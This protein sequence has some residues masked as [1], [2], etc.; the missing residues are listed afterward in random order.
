MKFSK[1]TAVCASLL[2]LVAAKDCRPN[3]ESEK[4]QKLITQ[5]GYVAG[6]VSF[7]HKLTS[8]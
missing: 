5:D 6:A 3:V 8:S 4:L 2:P 7:Q 1:A